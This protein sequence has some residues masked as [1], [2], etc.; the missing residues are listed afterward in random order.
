MSNNVVI[1]M[2]RNQLDAFNSWYNKT[3]IHTERAYHM[4]QR[5]AAAHAWKAALDTQPAQQSDTQAKLDVAQIKRS[6]L[7]VW[8]GSMPETNGKENWTVILHPIGELYEGYTVARSEYPD[9]IRYEADRLRWLLGDNT[10]RPDIVK[11]DVDKHSGYV[12]PIS[13]CKT[14]LDI[15]VK[16]LEEIRADLESKPEHFINVISSL[17]TTDEALSKI[18]EVGK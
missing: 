13:E 18:S 9:R 6:E 8:Y 7:V 14:K 17:A 10:E 16:A 11:V 15:A 1:P 3:Y 12:E 4:N 2:P 5:Y